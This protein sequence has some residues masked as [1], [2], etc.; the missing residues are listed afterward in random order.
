MAT[1][2]RCLLNPNIKEFPQWWRTQQHIILAAHNSLQ[3]AESLHQHL[4]S[5]P[6]PTSPGDA[7]PPPAC[8]FFQTSGSEGRPAWVALS[9]RALETSARAVNRH[10]NVSPSDRWLLALPTHH[11]GGFCVLVRAHIGRS[12]VFFYDSK[13]DPEKFAAHCT[14]CRA[15][16][17]SLVPAQVY[18]I[19]QKNIPAPCS[20][21]A[22]IVGGGHLD[23]ALAAEAWRLGW[24]V[25]PSY[26]MTEAASQIATL[27]LPPRGQ[28]PD[29]F[30]W[31]AVLEQW[32]CVTDDAGRLTISGPA[33]AAGKM[34]RDTPTQSWHWEK[35]NPDGLATRDR[36]ELRRQNDIT[37]LRYLGREA[38]WIKILGELVN[39]DALRRQLDTILN[40]E[41]LPARATII[42]VPD[43]RAGQ[44]L[45]LVTDLAP[46]LAETIFQKYNA[47]QSGLT[48]CMS[49]RHVEKLPTS[50]L[51]KILHAQLQHPSTQQF[52]G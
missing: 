45:E 25:I 32:S 48:R 52:W 14:E 17:T 36:V 22:V 44:K 8:C 24:P 15:T 34:V 23:P 47:T 9:R 30:E 38:A 27:T 16:L 41:Q 46:P 40:E 1:N 43:A 2:S 11:V 37:Y 21:R 3:E 39:I 42:A 6:S 51:G 19:V 28:A 20:L 5:V 35:F 33:L 26:G 7:A 50:P 4:I 10:L 31:L 29:N 12:P 49:V 13:W 18:D